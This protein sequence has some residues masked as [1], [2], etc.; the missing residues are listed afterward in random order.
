MW[1]LKGRESERGGWGHLF[2]WG[3][4]L[5][6]WPREE[7]LIKSWGNLNLPRFWTF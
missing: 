5:T 2:K 3:A 6:L 7:T 4:Y 1:E